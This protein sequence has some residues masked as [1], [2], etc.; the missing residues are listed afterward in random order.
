[1]S[2]AIFEPTQIEIGTGSG[3]RWVPA[4]YVIR[5]DGAK[6]Y[7]PVPRWEAKQI[8]QREGWSYRDQTAEEYKAARKRDLEHEVANM[9]RAANLSMQA[10]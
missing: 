3:Y 10:Q 8:C 4:V 7:P 9:E 6:L 5:P 2:Q 1:M